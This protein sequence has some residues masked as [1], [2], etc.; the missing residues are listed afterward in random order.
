M[1]ER[2]HINVK[3]TC[4]SK[5]NLIS[6][7]KTPILKFT[8]VS[9]QL[10]GPYMNSGTELES[11]STEDLHLLLFSDCV[12]VSVSL[13][14]SVPFSDSDRGLLSTKVSRPSDVKF[15]NRCHLLGGHTM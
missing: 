7:H 2:Q 5:R 4:T 9:G 3:K 6:V 10:V 8:E 12:S 11:Q 13:K 14:V 15:A 1:T